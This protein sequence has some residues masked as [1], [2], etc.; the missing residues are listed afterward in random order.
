[1]FEPT[2]RREEYDPLENKTIPNKIKVK[3]RC[4]NKMQQTDINTG[5]KAKLK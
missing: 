3:P 5:K 2:Q 1:M 4:E